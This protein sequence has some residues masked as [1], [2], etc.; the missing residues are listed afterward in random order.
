MAKKSKKRR[1]KGRVGR[2]AIKQSRSVQFG[3]LNLPKGVNMFREDP[4]SRVNLDILPYEVTTETHPDR[5]DEYEIAVPGSL[6]YKR[7]YWIHRN[8]GPNDE[9]VVCPSSNK[10]KCPICEYRAQLLRDGADWSDDSVRSL[11][12]SMRN[13]YVVVPKNHKNYDEKVHIWDIS[14]FL[15]QDK[16]NEE[17]QENEEH[18]TFPDLEEGYTL[19]IRFSEQQLGNNKFAETSRIDFIDRDEG[20]DESILDEVPDLDDV[21]VIPSYK[22]VEAMFL[23]G[24]SPEEIDDSEDEEID[25]DDVP[26]LEDEDE[27]QEA[28]EEEQEAEEEKPKRSRRSVKKEEKEA[29][30]KGKKKDQRASSKKSKGCPHGHAFGEDCDE[31]DECDECDKWED[32]IDAL[33]NK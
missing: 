22:A 27:E 14:Q 9:V 7:P 8:I 25:E 20:Y 33:E 24:M 28:E 31:H 19:R 32:C 5:D 12:A 3:H 2:N 11:K 13:L 18:E 10:Q 15:F 23:G 17:V 30:E 16:L 21:L 6:W 26:E 1:F 29:K 4:R